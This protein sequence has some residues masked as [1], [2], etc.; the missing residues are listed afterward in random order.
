[1]RPLACAISPNPKRFWRAVS[2]SA[3]SE[4]A[5]CG[6]LSEPSLTNAGSH[7]RKYDTRESKCPGSWTAV[8]DA[9]EHGTTV[10][11][12][13]G[14]RGAYVFDYAAGGSD[15]PAEFLLY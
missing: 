15:I 8:F 6:C 1:M 5:T 14:V 2:S 9:R 12:T 13:S 10:V 7:S 4:R 11:S 3:G